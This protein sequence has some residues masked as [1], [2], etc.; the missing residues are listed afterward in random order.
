MRGRSL[1]RWAVFST[2]T[3]NEN[4]P[5]IQDIAGATGQNRAVL[6]TDLPTLVPVPPSRAPGQT[7]PVYGRSASFHGFRPEL[8]HPLHAE[9]H[10]VGDPVACRNLTLDVRYVGALTR[11]SGGTLN[12]NTSTALYNQELFDAF[13]A[14]RRGENPE[15]LDRLL[16]GLDIAGTGNTTWTFGTNTGTYPTDRHVWPRRYLHHACYHWVA[17][18]Q[19]GPYGLCE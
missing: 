18:W 4:D 5:A 12:L 9:H 10:A 17:G 3:A 16:A 2:R 11:K 15:L 14:A 7:V 13:A 6:L 19:H 8:R 1:Q